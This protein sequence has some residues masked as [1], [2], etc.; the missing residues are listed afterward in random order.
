MSDATPSDDSSAI[1][2]GDPFAAGD[3]GTVAPER[4]STDEAAR[5]AG[6]GGLAITF[7]KVYFILQGLV[8]QVA[9][10]RVLGLDGYGALSSVLSAASITYNPIVTASIQGVSHAVARATPEEQP[11]AVRRVFALHAALAVLSSAAFFAA[12]PSIAEFMHA[13]HIVASLRVVSLV[14]LFYGVYSPLIGVLNGRR[15]FV[16]QAS[17]DVVFATFRTAAL[18]AGGVFFA[19]SGR[20]VEGAVTGFVAVAGGIFVASAFVIGFGKRGAGGPS[21]KKHLAF[22]A[23][24]LAGQVLLNLLLQADLT[25]LRRFAGEAAQAIG[26][27]A[28]AADPLVGTYRATQLYSFLPYQLLI[29]VTFILFPMLA[30]AHQAGDRAAVARYVS[31]G[32]R[33]ALLVAGAMVS[34]TSGLSG[35][36][37]RLVYSAEAAELGTRSMQILTLGF[38]AFAIL[39]VFTAVLSSLGR[40]RAGAM[41]I[42]VAFVLVVASCF[43]WARGV[44]FGERILWRTALSTS[45][46]LVLSTTCAAVLVYR[47]AGTVVS[48][49]TAFRVVVATAIAIFAARSLPAGG[50]IITLVFC[51]VVAALYAVCLVVLGEVGR[52][53]LTALGNIAGRGGK[54]SSQ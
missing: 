11:A 7:A 14:L 34:V 45:S 1:R 41:V 10:P 40:E 24:L 4:G 31:T 8:Q 27:P 53:D 39:G 30:A 52:A 48:K 5:T 3:A 43:T 15:R 32:V 13:P 33:V 26:L 37:I 2:G 25:L 23:P 54:R 29:S 46:G 38:G 18:I 36:L 47:T 28:A 21:V 22:L 50:K 51:A 42:L 12:A 44:P 49:A 9:L 19:R 6:R 35:P 20:G 17:F 16:A